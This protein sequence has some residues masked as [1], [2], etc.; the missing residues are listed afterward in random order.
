MR[1]LRSL[2]GL[3]WKKGLLGLLAAAGVL[4]LCFPEAPKKS[5]LLAAACLA[6]GAVKLN[7]RDTRWKYLLGGAVTAASVILMCQ[8]TPVFLG[9]VGFG[10]KIRTTI[11]WEWEIYLYNSICVLLVILVV[12]LISGRWRLSVAAGTFAMG[13]FALIN[14]FIHQ[15]RGRE[16]IYLDLYSVRTALNVAE[17]YTPRMDAFMW[18]YIGIW[19]A[20]MLALFAIPGA[21]RRR[22]G[23]CRLAALGV[24]A[25]LI[26]L[27][28]LGTSDR[29]SWTWGAKGTFMNGYYLNFYLS[30]RD[31][32]VSEPEAYS[33]EAVEQEQMRYPAGTGV[34]EKD[35][36]NILVVM[37]ES[38]ADLRY[39]ESGLRT[40]IPVM[41]FLDSLEENTIRGKAV[42]SIFG[43]N[44]ANSEF[45]FLTGNTMAFL[46]SG[47]LPY[48]FYIE[49]ELFSLPWL[50]AQQGYETFA[51]HP[52]LSNGWDRTRVYPLLGFGGYSFQED[53]PNENL[54]RNYVSD[55]E[56]YEYLLQM[57]RD[58]EDAPLF[59]FG[60]TMQN[61]GA[62]S[63]E[64]ERFRQTVWLEDYKG[65][66]EAEQYLSLVNY[67]DQALEYLLTELEAFEE[68]TVVLFFGDHL[69]K[70]ES[71]F[72]EELNRGS[73]TS[74]ANQ[75]LQYTVPF[76]VWA[77]FDI[78]EQTVECTSLNYLGR[79]LLETAGV[80][81]PPYY[82]FLKEMEQVI[83]AVSAEGY[84][85]AT[86]GTWL[87]LSEAQ[88]GEAQWL[89]RYAN[90]QHN[91]MFDRENRSEH[92]FG[93]YLE[94]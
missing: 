90:L 8:I 7:L 23:R 59:L 21:D 84:Y 91:S 80:E 16:L 3:N 70:L 69:P 88:G 17:Q 54:L 44:T 94:E 6:A 65:Y 87:P 61:H 67:S 57:L 15:F 38:F 81:L 72:Y 37:N 1:K 40:N 13:T 26:L 89:E 34:Q 52:Y 46:P 18:F 41:P 31:S 24:E 74:L 76:F 68:D 22:G 30:F 42:V 12:F 36:P 14:G 63:Y 75:M 71:T 82:Q 77:N 83:P 49:E 32:F 20:L 58:R 2:V 43:G 86:A 53:Y 27:L 73:T 4:L 10:M 47:T 48:Q 62:Y 79:Y 19:A 50:L 45:E 66:P 60:V 25:A 78:Q 33:P 35:M 56:M 29:P 5:L 51:T 39:L 93:Q 92:F 9:M 28:V 64:G 11:D 85:S 55:Q